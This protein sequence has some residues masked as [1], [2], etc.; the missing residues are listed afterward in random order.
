MSDDADTP[1]GSGAQHAGRGAGG[2]WQAGTSGDPKGRPLGSRGRATA[3]LDLLGRNSAESV[4]LAVIKAAEGGDVAAARLLLE[5]VWPARRGAPVALDLPPIRE[6]AD[7]VSA[8]DR[9]AEGV[10]VGDLSA[11]EAESLARLV[12]AQR[13]AIE[14]TALAARL[15]RLERLTSDAN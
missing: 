14:T 15:D 11:E 1:V 3:A 4:A 6:P 9:I 12:D 10:A 13:K 2:R 5:R 8:L 7:V